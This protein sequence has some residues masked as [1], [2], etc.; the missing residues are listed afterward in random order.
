[1]PTLPCV[2]PWSVGMSKH[3]SG[4][5][6]CLLKA[7]GRSA[8]GQGTMNNTL[9]GTADFGYYETL[10]GGHGAQDGA[11]GASGVHCHMS[12]TRI[13]DPEIMEHRFPVRLHRF[14]LRSGSGGEGCHRGGEGVE[15]IIEFL[16]PVSLSMLTQ[17]RTD[18]PF[19]MAG[20]GP[21]LPGAQFITHADGTIDAL[22]S[23]DARELEAG[24]RLTVRTP[25]GGGWGEPDGA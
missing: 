15:R 25:G 17:H 10:G 1:M 6:T 7:L 5:W 21:G 3:R 9:F 23:S 18:G 4:W 24:D 11:D 8:A 20:G 16:H 19:G 12:N 13:T 14:G 2:R 22:S